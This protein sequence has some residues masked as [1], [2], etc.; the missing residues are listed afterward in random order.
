MVLNI[1]LDMFSLRLGL[2]SMIPNI[3]PIVIAL[4]L[5]V[6]L[7]IPLDMFSLLIGSI[8]IGLAVDDTVHFMHNF[9]RYYNK[10]HNAAEAVRHTFL[11][12]GRALAVTT[13]VLS[14]GFFV[15]MFATMLNIIHFGLIAGIAIS[16]ALVANFLLAPALMVLFVRAKPKSETI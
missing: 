4:A 12:T 5:M 9:R 11:T 8:V 15:Y 13:I 3:T 2:L 7:N 1:P 6:V 14:L 10:T 16:L